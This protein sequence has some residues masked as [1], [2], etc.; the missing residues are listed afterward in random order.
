MSAPNY[1]MDH[2]GTSDGDA[3]K[4]GTAT[5]LQASPTWQSG[6][7]IRRHFRYVDGQHYHCL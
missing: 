4:I 7:P 1:L 6:E 2:R 5:R 3:L